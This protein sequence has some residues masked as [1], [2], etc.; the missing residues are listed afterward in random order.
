MCYS[1]NNLHSRNTGNNSEYY[2]K[3]IKE[4]KEQCQARNE[5]FEHDVKQK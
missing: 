1:R 3:V 4:L 2:E 5:V